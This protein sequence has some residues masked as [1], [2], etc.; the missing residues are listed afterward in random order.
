MGM[1][2][3]R[4]LADVVWIPIRSSQKVSETGMPGHAG[5]KEEFFGIHTLTV[6]V[7]DKLKAVKLRWMDL[8]VGGS[9]RGYVADS[10]EGQDGRYVPA[11]VH[12][13]FRDFS[14]LRL[15]LRN[16]FDG[17]EQEEWH[18]LQDF[19][20]TLSLKRENDVWIRPCEGYMEVA[21][22]HRN[23]EGDPSLLEVRASHLKDYLCARQMGLVVV[24]YR[25]R[26]QIF[27]DA[28][29]I[30][31]PDGYASDTADDDRWEGRVTEIH[32]G[33]MPY[34]G[35]IAAARIGRTD[36]GAE[37]D[38]P[39]L[40]EP[41]DDNVE[42]ESWTTKHNGPKLYRVSGESWRT[43]WINSSTC[44]PI[45]RHDR[46]TPTAFFVIDSS[47]RQENAEGLEESRRWLW[48]SPDVVPMLAHRRGGKLDWYTRDTGRVGCSGYCVHF[49]VNAIG[50]VNVYAK[51]IAHLPDWLQRQWSGYNV[52]PDGGV[53]DELLA[54]QV[55]AKPAESQ[56]PEVFLAT[57]LARLE[58]LAN[59]KL[60][61]NL[62]RDNHKLDDLISK[63]H[64][65]RSVN[66]EGLL[67]LSKDLYRLTGER[68]NAAALQ[69]IYPPSK[70][71]RWGSLKSLEK[72]IASREGEDLSKKLLS[73]LVSIY[74]LR[75]QDAHLPSN[76]YKNAYKLL[77]IDRDAP[78]VMQGFQL[79]D[80]CVGSIWSIGDVIDRWDDD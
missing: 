33:G 35:K 7:E 68:F 11:S 1:E 27:E 8:S 10:D 18:L 37:V 13:H 67:A 74:E 60:G 45:V 51:D 30:S 77:R 24:S 12:E 3:R 17:E 57:G 78:Y 53:S 9:H 6:R 38:V 50:L 40:G 26:V 39:E 69:K 28:Q 23:S 76:D 42:F 52:G 41:S 71:E 2:R 63:A 22:L 79:M 59:K 64:R 48:F 55:R 25:S 49:G 5:Y 31:W 32:E 34:G 62:L 72:V 75:K 54:S 19:V 46:V 73:G 61:I 44:S 56:A 4:S 66:E 80:A 65:F 58:H 43:E 29:H 21:R 70:G 20:V 36:V 15:V 47:G 14:G 16:G